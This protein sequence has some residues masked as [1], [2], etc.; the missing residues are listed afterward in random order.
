MT[1]FERNLN[2]RRHKKS[3]NAIRFVADS[4][5]VHIHFFIGY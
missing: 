3:T 2:K 5:Y 1:F 4:T